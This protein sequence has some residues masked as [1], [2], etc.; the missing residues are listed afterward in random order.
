MPVCSAATP[1]A[2]RPTTP[3]ALEVALALVLEP[4]LVVDEATPSVDAVMLPMLIP[5][6]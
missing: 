2:L 3:A 1:S 6:V 4:T 5:M